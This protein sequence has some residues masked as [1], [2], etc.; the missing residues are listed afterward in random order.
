MQLE[1]LDFIME[2][3]PG[4]SYTELRTLP[5]YKRKLVIYKIL[6]KMQKEHDRKDPSK[7]DDNRSL[8]RDRITKLGNK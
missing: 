8:F 4:F 1:E 7:Q 6:N 2:H 5:I 3:R